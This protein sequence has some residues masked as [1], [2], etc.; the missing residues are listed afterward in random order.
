MTAQEFNRRHP[1]GSR[2]RYYPDPEK[3]PYVEMVSER[4]AYT[5]SN[6]RAVIRLPG[7][8]KPVPLAHV[9]GVEQEV[10]A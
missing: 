7:F 8:K 3:A 10:P 4:A 5:L 2:V 9:R 6:G 1:P